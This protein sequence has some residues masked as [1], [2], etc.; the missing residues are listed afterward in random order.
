VTVLYG[1]DGCAGGWVVARVARSR[2]RELNP[3]FSVRADLR[4]IFAEARL[5]R[6]IV[7]IDIPIGIPE[8]AA[9]QCDIDARQKLPSRR[10]SCVFPVPTRSALPARNHVEASL[11]N[12]QACGRRVSAQTFGIL[13]KIR[14]IDGLMT[15]DLQQF[16]RETHP[17]VTFAVLAQTDLG[18]KKDAEGHA[19]RLAVLAG[20]G[21]RLSLE[22][23]RLYRN[24]LGRKL[25]KVDD[26]IDAAACLLTAKRIWN[27]QRVTF[28]QAVFLD[29]RKLRMEIVS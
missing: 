8:T 10:K 3:E 24:V 13:P 17:E 26:V 23:I 2:E 7:A 6:A 21:L 19:K 1:I 5:G 29:S 28:P 18:K 4:P 9:R 27:R 14:E 11:L 22:Q 16:V 12:H 15:P 20:H 25:V